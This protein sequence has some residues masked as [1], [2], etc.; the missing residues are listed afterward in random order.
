MTWQTEE[1]RIIAACAPQLLRM[2]DEKE[3]R[4]WMRVHTEFKGGRTDFL[5]AVAEFSA[6]RD[7]KNEINAALK[8]LEK[9]E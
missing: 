3:Q 4:L 9:G 2:I 8:Q 5:S 7:Q 6:L 1:L